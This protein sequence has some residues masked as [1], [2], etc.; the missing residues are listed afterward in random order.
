VETVIIERLKIAPKQPLNL[1][2]QTPQLSNQANVCNEDHCDFR[3]GAADVRLSW[4]DKVLIV[5]F[6]R[7]KNL[8]VPNAD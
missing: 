3:L 8:S 2:R 6:E 5:G 4:D 7:F 1:M